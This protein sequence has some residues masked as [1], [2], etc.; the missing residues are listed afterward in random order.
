MSS[1]IRLRDLSNTIC[2]DLNKLILSKKKINVMLTGGNTVLKLYFYLNKKIKKINLTNI[3]FWLTDERT[4]YIDKNNSNYLSIKNTLFKK[5]NKKKYNF[6]NI[7]SYS[8]NL[9]KSIKEYERFFPKRID[10]MIIT[11]GEDGHIASLFP[12]V[13]EK[14]ISKN[15]I[16]VYV[17]DNKNRNRIS[18]K[19][20]IFKQTDKI[21]ALCFGRKKKKMYN[22]LIKNNFK[23]KLP[24]DS[25]KNAN[26]YF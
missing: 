6:P 26:W 1:E 24:A 17:R 7:I 18:I 3:N 4:D 23:S 20:K 8:S 9:K 15:F 11:L 22:K 2:K 25:L 13:K 5:M 16:K 10:L 19:R 21:F 12:A 14:S